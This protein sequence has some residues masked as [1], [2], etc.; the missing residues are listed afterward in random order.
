MS[1]ATSIILGRKWYA[2]EG[3][4]TT[5]LPLVF[6]VSAACQ[7]LNMIILTLPNIGLVEPTL[8]L[9]KIRSMVIGGSTIPF[10]GALFQIWMPSR[11]KYHN[12]LLL[13]ITSYWFLVVLLGTSEVIIMT[14][15]IPVLIIISLMMMTTFI[16]TWKTGRL[17][18]VKNE[19][20][21]LAFIL[22]IASQ[23]LRVP[24][25]TTSL[26]YLPDVLL[27]IS[28]ASILIAIIN[29][30]Y[31]REIKS[32]REEPTELTAVTY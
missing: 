31:S 32:S 15:A 25:M 22:M 29:P 17:K 30:W 21:V 18:E 28:M 1:L 12:K 20:L 10:L 3:R 14:L 9:F 2:Q 5:D 19:L 7:A 6:A 13:A 11:Q 4:L 26:F 24:L 23:L 8:E 27:T 16:I